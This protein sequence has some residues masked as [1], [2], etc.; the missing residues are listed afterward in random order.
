M[1]T[2]AKRALKLAC[3]EW[4]HNHGVMSVVTHAR[5]ACKYTAPEFTALEMIMSGMKDSWKGIVLS[6]SGY[7]Y[8]FVG[9]VERTLNW[10][11]FGEHVDELI[12]QYFGGKK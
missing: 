4:A 3:E 7:N 11:S 1:T 9:E 10:S 2:T 6:M 12:R 8:E 5:R